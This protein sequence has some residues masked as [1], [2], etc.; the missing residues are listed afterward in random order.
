MA[1]KKLKYIEIDDKKGILY[2]GGIRSLIIPLSFIKE[3][4]NSFNKIIGIPG[5]KILIYKIGEGLGREYARTLKNI[6]LEKKIILD[7]DKEILTREVYNAIFASAGWGRVKIKTFKKK[8]ITIEIINTPS[9]VL[10]KKGEYSLERGIL[11]GA[12]KE[13]FNKEIYY[14]VIKEERKKGLVVFKSLTKIPEEFLIKEKLI[15]IER[16]DLE[17]KIKE[18][19]KELDNAKGALMNILE[20]VEEARKRAEEEKNKTQSIIINFTDGLLVFDDKNRLSLIN[21]QAEYFFNVKAKDIINKSILDLSAFPDFK[22]LITFLGKEIKGIFRKELKIRK[23]LVLEIS[24]IPILKKEEKFETLV[25]LHDITREKTIERMKTEFVSIAAHQL[26]TPLS[27]IKWTLRMLLDGDLGKI[28]EEQGDFIKKTYGSNERMITL[29]N[30][31]LNVTRIEEGRF[32]YKPIPTQIQNIIQFIINS[33]KEQ[34]KKKKIA[35]TFKKSK[36]ELP[37]VVVDVEKIKLAIQ[38]L[39]DN[40]IKYTPAGG[41]ITISISSNKKK[42]EISIKDTGIGVP[43]D[44]QKRVFTRFFRAANA[45][46]IESEGTGLGLFIAK[47]IINAHK[48]EIWFKSEEN[49]GSTFYFTLPLKSSII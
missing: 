25:I 36:K 47:N 44:Q 8:Q 20:D 41:K 4:N 37:Q 40:S 27:A 22:P 23:E 11:A 31:L 39:L 48:G 45:I 26:R 46:K 17:K 13:I 33:Y 43:K 14:K 9:G 24:T 6:L 34:I 18:R 32:L 1:F 19:T 29:I 12:Y 35:L 30:A 38:N 21:P 49:K 28:T 15:L 2:S 5:T 10:I 42:I 3:L 7:L 16:K